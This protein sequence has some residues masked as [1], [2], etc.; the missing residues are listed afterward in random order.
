MKRLKKNFAHLWASSL[1]FC[2]L[3]EALSRYFCENYFEFGTNLENDFVGES[4]LLFFSGSWDGV[5]MG[6]R[7]PSEVTPES[8]F[9]GESGGPNE[10]T[11]TL[12]TGNYVI[13]CMHNIYNIP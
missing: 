7:E 11:Q 12:N 1:T 4:S 9:V 10:T 6:G 2:F 8:L 5:A 13:K 3:S